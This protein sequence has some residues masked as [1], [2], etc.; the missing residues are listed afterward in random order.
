MNKTNGKTVAKK[1]VSKVKP[2]VAKEKQL[3]E[4][5]LVSLG[6]FSEKLI[7]RLNAKIDKK[8]ARFEKKSKGIGMQVK[9]EIQGILKEAF[10]YGKV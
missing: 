5:Q 2:V 10:G 4:K 1:S 6:K 3:T 7:A 8:V 9:T